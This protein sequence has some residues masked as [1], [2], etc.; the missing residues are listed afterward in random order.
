MTGRMIPDLPPEAA[1]SLQERLVRLFP[2]A[3][4][5]DQGSVA[6]LP[7]FKGAYTLAL[8]LPQ[9]MT[10]SCSKATATLEAGW[11]VYAG[12]AHGPGGIVARL[13]RHFRREK[14]QHWHVD[15]FT[16]AAPPIFALAIRDG[17]ECAIVSR[18]SQTGSFD[19]PM[20]GFG[21]SDCRSCV[22]HLLRLR[23]TC[24]DE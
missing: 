5:V 6:T 13:H 20:P 14:K 11:F 21:S 8:H 24:A 3:L 4:W 18:L 19:F 15:Q 16:I 10:F 1:I 9:A 2:E 12:S 23:K 17:S 22:S 7:S